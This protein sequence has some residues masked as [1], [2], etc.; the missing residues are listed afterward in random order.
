MIPILV[1]NHYFE[2]CNNVLSSAGVIY[3]SMSMYRFNNQC[4]TV[5]SE[6]VLKCQTLNMGDNARNTAIPEI[7]P[8]TKSIIPLT[9]DYITFL[10]FSLIQCDYSNLH[11]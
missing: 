7:Y 2:E 6:V 5:S 1:V 9:D 8:V 3:H 4:M 11:I 10:V